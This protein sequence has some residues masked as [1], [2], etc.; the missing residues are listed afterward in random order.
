MLGRG[1]ERDADGYG[2][3]R[4][5][6]TGA[7]QGHAMRLVPGLAGITRLLTISVGSSFDLKLCLVR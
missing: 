3:V 4:A 1:G 7:R 5:I 2:V 6:R